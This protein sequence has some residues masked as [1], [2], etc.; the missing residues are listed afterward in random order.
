MT[1]KCVK[2]KTRSLNQAF[3]LVM[4]M[5]YKEAKLNPD[6]TLLLTFYNINI[7]LKNVKK[8]TTICLLYYLFKSYIYWWKIIRI[9]IFIYTPKSLLAHDIDHISFDRITDKSKNIYDN[10]LDVNKGY[11]HS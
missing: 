10:K 11:I 5:I 6:A 9:Y 3:K 4:C 1:N 7:S 8:V 2:N